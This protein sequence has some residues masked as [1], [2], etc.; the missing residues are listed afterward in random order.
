MKQLVWKPITDIIGVYE[1]TVH[2][3]LTLPPPFPPES[4]YCAAH[5]PQGRKSAGATTALEQMSQ[6]SCS[7][8]SHIYEKSYL[9]GEARH[10]CGG[11]WAMENKSQ[12]PQMKVH[13]NTIKLCASNECNS[14][15]SS[16]T[17]A[18]V[19][20]N[21]SGNL[22]PNLYSK[23]LSSYYSERVWMWAAFSGYVSTVKMH[24]TLSEMCHQCLSNWVQLQYIVAGQK[25]VNYKIILKSCFLLPT[26][27]RCLCSVFRFGL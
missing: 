26:N 22:K 24:G 9:H 16:Y 3:K 13:W 5:L 18:S 15:F 7:L 2:S 6:P 23:I 27:K 17:G 14:K 8:L 19:L 11:V 12:H 25:W 21:T 4:K 20:E 1:D 10:W